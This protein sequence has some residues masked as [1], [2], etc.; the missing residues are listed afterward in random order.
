MTCLYSRCK[1]S[2]IEVSNEDMANDIFHLTCV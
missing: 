2:D 1:V